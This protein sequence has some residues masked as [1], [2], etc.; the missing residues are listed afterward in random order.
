MTVNRAIRRRHAPG[1]DAPL[2]L[3]QGTEPVLRWALVHCREPLL[4]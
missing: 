3:P 1:A 4:G 2:R